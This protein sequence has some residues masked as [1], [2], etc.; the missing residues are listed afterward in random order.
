MPVTTVLGRLKQ[1]NLKF[2]ACLGYMRRLCLE[3]KTN[4]T[5]A[6]YHLLFFTKLKETHYWFMKSVWCD[7]NFKKMKTQ[8]T[9]ACQVVKLIL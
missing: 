3:N 7:Q 9:L 1:E 2:E 6:Q 8:N 4:K 5:P